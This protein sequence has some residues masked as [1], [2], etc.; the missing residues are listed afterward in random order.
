[1][2]DVG[3]GVHGV[4]DVNCDLFLKDVDGHRTPF[5]GVNNGLAAGKLPNLVCCDAA[6]LPFKN[7][8]FRL[9]VSNHMIEHV[10][11]PFLVLE[12]MKRVSKFKVRIS[13][14]HRY[15]D[16]FWFVYKRN[17]WQWTKKHHINKFTFTWF[18]A[19]A[20][21]LGCNCKV[22]A[23]QFYSFPTEFIHFF[24]IPIEI[25]VIFEKNTGTRVI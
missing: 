25:T 2:L 1:M 17:G 4:G 8:S 7:D 11:K 23:S 24:K 10:P 19:A 12:E 18:Q 16:G 9:V 3:C 20:K 6:Y 13:C 22:K 5:K 21:R 15:A 14:P